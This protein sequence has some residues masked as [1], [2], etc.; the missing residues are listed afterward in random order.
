MLLPAEGIA[1]MQETENQE[2]KA[3]LAM[4][5]GMPDKNEQS[6]AERRQ[7][8]DDNAKFFSL[9][10]G[11][12]VEPVV[13]DSF[14]GEWVRARAA[15]RDS[16]LLYLH[17]GA[18]VF[19]SPL[20]HRHLVAALSEATGL[21]AFSLDYRLAP[22]SPFPAAVEDSVAAVRWLLAQGI[23]ADH[24]V[25]AGDSAGGGLTVATMLSLRDAGGPL[26]LAGVCISPWADLTV[27]AKSF[28][29]NDEARST[30]DRLSKYAKLYLNGTDAKHPLASPIFADLEGLPP[31]LIQ[32]GGAEPFYDDAIN[33]EERA[34]SCDVE[35]ELEIWEEMIHVWHYFYPMLTA[36]RDA[37]GH[38]GEF[39]KS[40]IAHD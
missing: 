30:R 3:V 10:E 19:C 27:T 34:K 24:L 32:V 16:V 39:V 37:I 8:D 26:P 1:I 13:T 14:K 7:Q 36:G 22:E 31:L 40:H 9:P 17:G 18:Y 25:I 15:R 12:T 33:L 21:A 38:V 35:T 28:T 20:S 2:L 4:L 11:V 29:T 23:A 6:I 5:A